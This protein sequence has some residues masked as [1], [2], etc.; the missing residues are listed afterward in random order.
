MLCSVSGSR[1]EVGDVVEDMAVAEVY[2]RPRETIAISSKPLS[3]VAV[4]K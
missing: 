1:Y 2:I 4:R 3:R